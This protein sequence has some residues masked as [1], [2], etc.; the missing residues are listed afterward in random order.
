MRGVVGWTL[1]P[2]SPSLCAASDADQGAGG[3]FAPDVVSMADVHRP[4]YEARRILGPA[5]G[6]RLGR[7]G[8]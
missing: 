4:A 2:A 8:S 5:L 6:E 7:P 1:S 3:E